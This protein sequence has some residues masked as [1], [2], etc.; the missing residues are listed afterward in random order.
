M[1]KRG[2]IFTPI[3]F[4]LAGAAIAQE[5]YTVSGVESLVQKVVL[6]NDRA[7][8]IGGVGRAQ[9]SGQHAEATAQERA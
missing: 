1:I 9:G 2:L 4:A 7:F 5:F 3:M 6:M 8:E